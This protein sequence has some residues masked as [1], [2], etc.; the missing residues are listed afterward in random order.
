MTVSA[1][2]TKLMTLSV[3]SIQRKIKVT[4]HKL[5]TVAS[6][7]NFEAVILGDDSNLE[8]LSRIAQATAALFEA[9]ADLERYNISLG[10]KVKLMR[11]TVI[12]IFLY[13][14][15]SLT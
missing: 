4:V 12:S 15:E 2:K 6:F 5:C 10:P 9:E 11:T 7:E 1:E 13:A 14:F 8:G 3:N